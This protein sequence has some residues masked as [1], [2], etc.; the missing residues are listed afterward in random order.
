MCAAV[1]SCHREANDLGKPESAASPKTNVVSRLDEKGRPTETMVYATAAD[2]RILTARTVDGQG[3]PKWTDQ[4]SYEKAG[5]HR[6]AAIRRL[7]AD[8]HIVSVS[9][10]YSSD[11]TKRRIVTGPDGKQIPEAEQATFLEE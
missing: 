8:G 5:D 10:L 11:G 7:R 9:F 2:G 3:K 1:V 4:Y 6:P